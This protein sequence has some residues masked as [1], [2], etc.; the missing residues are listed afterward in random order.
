MQTKTKTQNFLEGFLSIYDLSPT[1]DTPHQDDAH[2]IE[3]CWQ[4]V[5]G[6]LQQSMNDFDYE[7]KTQHK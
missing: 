6:F 1:I 5:G 3:K 2:A 7:Q 4:E